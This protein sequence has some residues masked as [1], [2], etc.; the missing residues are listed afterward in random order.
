MKNEKR[1]GVEQ[2]LVSLEKRDYHPEDV[3]IAF[4]NLGGRYDGYFVETFKCLCLMGVPEK[5]AIEECKRQAVSLYR[6]ERTRHIRISPAF[7]TLEEK[8]RNDLK[9]VQHGEKYFL[10]VHSNL[11]PER[12]I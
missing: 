8:D 1:L 10:T 6:R 3:D 5:D 12:K 7:D 4:A 11:K 9:A 2:Q